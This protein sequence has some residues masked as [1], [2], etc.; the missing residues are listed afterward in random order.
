MAEAASQPAPVRLSLADQALANV[1]GYIALRVIEDDRDALQVSLLAELLPH[2]NRAQPQV[3]AL[4]AAAAEVMA[5]FPQRN[6]KGG[7]MAWAQ[8]QLTAAGAMQE[9]LWWRGALAFDAWKQTKPGGPH[10]P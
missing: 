4:A 9:F 3:A 1:L 7:S 10:E 6:V 8:A 5:A 2:V